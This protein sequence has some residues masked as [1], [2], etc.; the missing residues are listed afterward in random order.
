MSNFPPIAIAFASA[1]RL[2]AEMDNAILLGQQSGSVSGLLDRTASAEK[3]DAKYTRKQQSKDKRMTD[4]LDIIENMRQQLADLEAQMA[5]RF[6]ALKAKYGDDVIGGMATT[7]L[8]EDELAELDTDEQKL[9]AL[10]DKLL[11]DKGNVK[12]QYRH[13]EEAEYLEAWQKAQK[14]KP[15]VAKYDG[16][17][18]LEANER[19]EVLEAAHDADLIDNKAKITLSENDEYQATVDS[20]IDAEGSKF[21]KTYESTGFDFS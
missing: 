16:R 7:F 9:Q 4:I 21:T 1:A 18:T 12:P 2:S 20:E 10:A 17:N 8:T 14:L 5:Q 13:L 6:E 15:V 19:Q 11:D 3:T